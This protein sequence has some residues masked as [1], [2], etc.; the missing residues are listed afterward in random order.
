MIPIDHLTLVIS[1][2]L[3]PLMDTL[4]LV[5]EGAGFYRDEGLVVTKIF[6]NGAGEAAEVTSKRG[7]DL[8]PIGIEPLFSGYELGIRLQLFLSRLARYT[9]VLSVLD[10]SPIATLAD[11]RG[12]TIGVH[13]L[14]TARMSGR[15]AVESALGSAGVGTDEYALEAIGFTDRA[16]AALT[17]RRVDAAAFPLYEL[18]PYQIAGANL[19]IFRHPVLEDIA[20]TGFAA[21]PETI[22]EKADQFQRFSRAIVKASLLVHWNAP[23]S[24]RLML[25]AEGSPF[26]GDDVRKYTQMLTLWQNEL[27]ARDP[28]SRRIGEI[29]PEGVERYIR[30]LAEFGI[31]SDPI[32]VAAILTDQFVD[33]ANDFDRAALERFA[34]GLH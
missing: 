15:M 4:D 11:F 28:A 33:G 10:D 27:P 6:V 34:L 12:K 16:L 23:A 26:T 29:P 19:R 7:G 13:T 5:A 14:G 32:P 22:A 8:C 25:E 21:A 30:L 31:I 9:Y 24:A 1:T 3:P 20:N 18:L 17:S 2:G